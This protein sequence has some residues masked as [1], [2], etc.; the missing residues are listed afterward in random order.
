MPQTD[1]RNRHIQLVNRMADTLGLDLRREVEGAR[2]S[3]TQFDATVTRCMDCRDPDGCD[4]W[5]DQHGAGARH[6]PGLCRNKA[7]LE[8]LREYL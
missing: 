2:L 8:N 3:A 1:K 5:L 4:L 6:T 7:L